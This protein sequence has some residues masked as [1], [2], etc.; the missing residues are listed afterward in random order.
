M[1]QDASP[2]TGA[3]VVASRLALYAALVNAGAHTPTGAPLLSN[4]GFDAYGYRGVH[5]QSIEISTE[6]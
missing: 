4:A 6:Y 1:K 5:Q 3:A 2:P